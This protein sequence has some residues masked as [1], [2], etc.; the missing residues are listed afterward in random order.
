MANSRDSQKRV[1]D[2]EQLRVS[3]GTVRLAE[4]V[5]KLC[6]RTFEQTKRI[7]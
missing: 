2:P 6:L 1:L 7:D 3:I 4:D 5:R